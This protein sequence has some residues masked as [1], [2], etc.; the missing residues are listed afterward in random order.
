MKYLLAHDFGTSADKA[1]LFSVDGKL[2]GS[3]TVAYPSYTTANNGVEQDPDDWWNCFCQTTKALLAENGIAKEDVLAVGFDG[4]FPN[5]LCLDAEG[6]KLENAYIWQDKRAVEVLDEFKALLPKDIVE[7]RMGH[8]G[9]EETLTKA[10]WLKKNKPEV[11]AKTAMI[12]PNGQDY[13]IFKLT[14]IA[15]TEVSAVAGYTIYDREAQDWDERALAATGLTKAQL[16]AIHKRTDVIGEVLEKYSDQCGLAAG[17]K[18]V[19]GCGDTQASMLGAG[20]YKPGTAYFNGG[21]S[22]GILVI[23]PE[24]FD[25]KGKRLGGLTASSG[26]SFS[27][28]KNEICKIEQE[29]ADKDPD[30]NVY[31]IINEEIESAPIGSGGVMFHPYLSGERAP[32]DNGYA[33]GSFVGIGLTTKR[34]EILRS[35]IEGIGL[36]IGVIMDRIRE[37]GIEIKEMVMVGGLAKGDITRQIFADILDC[38]LNVPKY[39]EEAATIGDA[40]I[41]GVA[42]GLYENEEEALEKYLEI[43][44]TTEPIPENVEIYKKLKPVYE[45]IYEGLYDVYPEIFNLKKELAK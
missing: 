35:V 44:K 23:P 40:I 43:V 22:A 13:I 14:G 18:L 31:D 36:N 38:K 21:T 19:I 2:I 24:G 6:N 10:Y 25:A 42:I 1:S 37:A 32:R 41:A 8:V 12:L 20:F 17:T 34:N 3:K 7:K 9:P 27:W 16:P 39:T 30:K 15:A 33:Q 4:T 29:M 28:L 45:K 11:F 26:T 5:L